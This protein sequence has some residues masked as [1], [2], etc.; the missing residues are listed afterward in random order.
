MTYQ[1]IEI[2]DCKMIMYLKQ[3]FFLQNIFH[4]MFSFMYVNIL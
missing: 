2:T 1:P 3:L 4:T